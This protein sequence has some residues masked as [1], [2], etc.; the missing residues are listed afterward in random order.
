VNPLLWLAC[1]LFRLRAGRRDARP[2]AQR[3]A[4]A[5]QPVIDVGGGDD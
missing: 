2:L 5:R 1:R 4:D 3:L